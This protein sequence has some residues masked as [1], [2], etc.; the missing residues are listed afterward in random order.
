MKLF[1][2][3]FKF[4]LKLKRCPESPHLFFYF[5]LLPSQS[6]CQ[7]HAS[8]LVVNQFHFEMSGSDR[9]QCVWNQFTLPVKWN[10]FPERPV[11][12]LCHYLGSNV[13]SVAF[14][15]TVYNQLSCLVSSSLRLSIVCVALVAHNTHIKTHTH[16]FYTHSSLLVWVTINF[17]WFRSFLIASISPL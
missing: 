3:H 16:T 8:L 11:Y 6:A 15:I 2:N 12:V 13:I 10:T 9:I 5:F 7:G 17:K 1:F 14:F 4:Y